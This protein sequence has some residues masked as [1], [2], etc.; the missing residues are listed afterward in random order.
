MSTFML[1]VGVALIDINVAS[2]TK[3]LWPH[4]CPITL[5][6]CSRVGSYFEGRGE[7]VFDKCSF[8][9]LDVS[10]SWK[11]TFQLFPSSSFRQKWAQRVQIWVQNQVLGNWEVRVWIKPRQTKAPRVQICIPS[12]KPGGT[13]IKS[14]KMPPFLNIN[15]AIFAVL[16]FLGCLGRGRGFRPLHISIFVIERY[17]KFSSLTW[18]IKISLSKKTNLPFF[19][20]LYFYVRRMLCT[21][22]LEKGTQGKL[23]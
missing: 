4:G 13:K 14:T 2:C 9:H 12:P 15:N 5:M 20:F 16:V 11:L 22:W 19:F 7:Q 1:W 23:K 8:W 21:K 17:S 10:F 18:K 3:S 6:W